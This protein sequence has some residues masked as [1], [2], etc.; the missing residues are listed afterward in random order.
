MFC[1]AVANENKV[2]NAKDSVRYFTAYMYCFQIVK[3]PAFPGVPFILTNACPGPARAQ[4][5]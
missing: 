5:P 1:R 2:E 4:Y 3:T